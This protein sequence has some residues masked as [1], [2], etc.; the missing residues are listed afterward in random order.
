MKREI[1]R[2]DFLVA[3]G[4]LV[5]SFSAASLSGAVRHSAGAIRHASLACRSGEAG[6]MA[7]GRIRWHGDRVHRKMRF[8]AGHVYGADAVGRRRTVRAY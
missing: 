6:L 5:V 2:R 4:A 7:C 1:S 3:S 8:R